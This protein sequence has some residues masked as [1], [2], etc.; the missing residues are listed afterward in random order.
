MSSNQPRLFAGICGLICLVCF[1]QSCND[2]PS[3]PAAGESDN[4]LVLGAKEYATGAAGF[5]R[6]QFDSVLTDSR[7]PMGALCVWEGMAAARFRILPT[8]KD[9]LSITLNIRGY[10]TRA[11]STRHLPLD[12]LGYRFT[13]LQLDPYPKIGVP[14]HPGDYIATLRIAHI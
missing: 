12:T 3:S 1:S 14:I 13:L 9:T 6:L 11:D 5:Y 8:A 10:T 4:I 2:G 7:C